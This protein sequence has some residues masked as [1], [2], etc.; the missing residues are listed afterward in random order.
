[1]GSNRAVVSGDSRFSTSGLRASVSTAPSGAVLIL[2]TSP[3]GTPCSFTSDPFC[4]AL[5]T[6]SVRS[7]TSERG[8]NA[9]L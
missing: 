7:S 9:R 3:T 2:A 1:L 4:R 8:T 5:P 6:E